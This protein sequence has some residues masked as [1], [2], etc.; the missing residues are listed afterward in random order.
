MT[1]EEV[2]NLNRSELF[3]KVIEKIKDKMSIVLT[4]KNVYPTDRFLIFSAYKKQKITFNNWW[5]EFDNDEPIGLEECPCII[6]K[7]VLSLY[8]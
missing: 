7:K 5:V 1:I 4:P 3:D 8:R 6:Q 2:S